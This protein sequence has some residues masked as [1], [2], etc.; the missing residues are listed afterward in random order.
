V[1]FVAQPDCGGG[2]EGGGPSITS[3]TPD[4]VKVGSTD[5]QLTIV[6]SGFGTSPTVNLPLGVTALS[7]QASTNT[8]VIIPVSVSINATIG[9]NSLTI[10]AGGETSNPGSLTLDGPFY[11]I[12][13]DDQMGHCYGCSTTVERFVTY[14]VMNFSGSSAGAIPIGESYTPV[15]GW[16]CTQSR[17]TTKVTLCSGGDTTLSDGEFTDGWTLTADGYTPVDCGETGNNVD[18]WQWCATGR[19]IGKLTG[20]VHTN[21]V[22]INGYVNPTTPM[23]AGHVINP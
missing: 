11:M 4:T 2:G 13:E 7:G 16:N 21:A 5:V 23:P 17:P 1:A 18:D 14:Q 10:T 20:W 12:V 8:K 15:A 22:S 19:S 6:G 3:V 9:P